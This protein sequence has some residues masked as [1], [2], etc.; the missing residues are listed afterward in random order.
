MS[1]YDDDGSYIA[2]KDEAKEEYGKLTL[3]DMAKKMD[4]IRGLKDAVEEKL[5]KINAH[6]DALRLDLIPAKMEEDG[7]EGLKVEGV[8]RVSLTGDMYVRVQN[9]LELYTWLKEMK[10]G[11]LIQPTVNSSTLK[12]SIK[13]RIKDGKEIPSEEILKVTPFTRASITKA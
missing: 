1:D 10:L 8:G 13:K 12:A 3:V 6:Y 5:K 2:L 4:E 7:I 11:D 9:K